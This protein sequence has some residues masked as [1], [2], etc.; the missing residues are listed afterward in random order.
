M[1]RKS[2]VFKFQVLIIHWIREHRHGV[3]GTVIFHLLLGISLVCMGISEIRTRAEMEIVLDMPAPEL[4]QQVQEELKKQEEIVQQ[5]TDEEVERMLRSLAVNEDVAKNKKVSESH[6]QVEKYIEQ[7]QEELRGDY[8]DRY[9]AR[10]DK[11]YKEDSLRYQKE[12]AARALDSLQST[13]YVG[14]S[15]V[16]YN[17]KGRYKT[18]LPIP[19]FKCEFGGKVVVTVVVNRKGRVIKAEVVEAE[20]RQDDCLREVAVNAALRSE[21]NVDEKASERQ[22]GTITYNFVKQ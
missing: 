12:K 19:I 11:N 7:I 17:I 10:K 4:I 14:K 3:M 8:G 9:K 6:E 5:S 21:F 15:S 16:S 1:I 18:Y 22:S 13:V 2:D 20:S